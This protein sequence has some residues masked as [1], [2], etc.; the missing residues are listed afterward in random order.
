MFLPPTCLMALNWCTYHTYLG[1]SI[2]C[3]PSQHKDPTALSIRDAMTA[4]D[5]STTQGSILPLTVHLTK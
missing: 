5:A 1:C 4:A 3:M 2:E